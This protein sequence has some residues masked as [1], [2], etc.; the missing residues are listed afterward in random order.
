M[1][2]KNPISRS[3]RKTGEDKMS[4]LEKQKNTQPRIAKNVLGRE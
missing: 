3:K 1:T 2:L 4:E